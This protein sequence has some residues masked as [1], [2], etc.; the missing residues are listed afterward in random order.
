MCLKKPLEKVNRN[1]ME[2]NAK[3]TSYLVESIEG[4]ETVKAF[5]GERKVNLETEKKFIKLIKSIF[6]HGYVNNLQNSLKNSVKNIF[7]IAIL[8]IGGYYVLSNQITVGTL[9]SFNA[10]L[11][12]F[13]EPIERII[14]LQPQLQSAIVAADR[15]GEILDLEVEKSV[16]EDKKIS[17]SS[18]LSTIELKNIDFRYGTRQLVL[19]NINMK[20]KPG[21]KIA[22]VGESGSGKTTIAKLLMNFYDVEKGEIT[23][24]DCNIKDINKEILR[25]KISYISQDSFFFSG[26]I[27]E[28]LQFANPH[29]SY[30]DII[31][32]CKQAQIHDYINS[33]PTRYETF[34]EEKGSNL[35]GGQKQRLAIARAIIKKPEI[36]IMDEATSNLDSITE[37]AIQKTIESCTN[38]VTTIMIAHRL[39][40]IKQCNTIYVMNKGS[41]IEKGS[42]KELIDKRGY[43]YKLWSGQTL[44]GDKQV[45]ANSIGG[46]KNEL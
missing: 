7:S 5:N 3:L 10:L 30:E 4:E 44:D 12:Y 41:I 37:C 34:L 43:Y 15:L 11:T 38:N 45:V 39:S 28:N 29:A 22:L 32:A 14:N 40:T 18:L 42:H 8:C 27:K 20:I 36:L 24:C 31:E 19:N 25:D 46:E 26:T 13:I 21:E 33:L 6:K 17:P 23:I 1:A 16:D 9:I 2:D 35:S